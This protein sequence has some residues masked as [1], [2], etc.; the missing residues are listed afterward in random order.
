MAKARGRS[1]RAGKAKRAPG[2]EHAELDKRFLWT[3]LV[4]L[5]LAVAWLLTAAS[6][7]SFDAGDAPGHV[8]WPYND[9]TRNWIGVVGANASYAILKLIGLGA[10]PA[11]LAW[12]LALVFSA[13]GRPYKHPLIRT[14]GIVLIMLSTAGA[15]SA[16]FPDAGPMPG[17]SGGMAGVVIAAQMIP[18]TGDVGS[19]MIL[20]A[21]FIAGLI[22]TF[23]RL[24]FVA[25][26]WTMRQF[27]S[28]AK[29]AGAKA[30]AKAA[31]ARIRQTDLDDAEADIAAGRVRRRKKQGRIDEMAGGIGG[32]E[33][34]NPDLAEVDPDEIEEEWEDEWEEDADEDEY[35]EEED[36]EE[37]DEEEEAEDDAGDEEE[38]DE[39]EDELPGAPQI[40]D[41]D[42]LREKISALPVRFASAD[43]GSATQADLDAYQQ[44]AQAMEGYKFPTLELLEEPEEGFNELLEEHVREQAESLEEALREYKIR[45]EVVG[46]E[47]GPVITLYHVKLAPGTKVRRST[48]CRATW[49]GRSRPSTSASSPTRR[50]ATRS[51]SRCPTRRWRRCASAS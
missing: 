19:V 50:G 22:L 34:F 29:K 4:W 23:D 15:A 2:H 42:K 49:L 43:K 18:H 21:V 45:G 37:E 8:A 35:D 16:L 3:R 30:K 6:L 24:V 46:I 36:Y 41:R 44:S 40:F 9:P 5:A 14:G 51:A 28:G 26:A 48:R 13:S 33:A 25:A 20:L 39:V 7:I 17:L 27:A 10:V 11:M 32:A 38:E 12:L 1:A 31:A 47:S